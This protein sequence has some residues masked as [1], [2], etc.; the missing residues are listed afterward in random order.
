MSISWLR[1]FTIILQNITIERSWLKKR[2]WAKGTWSFS[3]LFLIT[4]YESKIMLKLKFNF[5]KN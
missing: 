5:L 1:C 2:N 4:A 3:V